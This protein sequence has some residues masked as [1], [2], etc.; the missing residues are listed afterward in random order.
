MSKR[1]FIEE[2]TSGPTG[3]GTREVWEPSTQE[4]AELGLVRMEW[5]ESI[6]ETAG[7]REALAR[8]ALFAVRYVAGIRDPE[9]LDALPPLTAI[10]GDTHVNGIVKP[11]PLHENATST[12]CGACVAWSERERAA[13]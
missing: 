10:D 4:L 12:L 2:T 6:L 1:I 3:S 13:S 5:V 9:N 11:C 8:L 7:E